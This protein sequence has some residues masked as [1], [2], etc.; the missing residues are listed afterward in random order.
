MHRKGGGNK[1]PIIIPLEGSQETNKTIDPRDE[2]NASEEKSNNEE[3]KD[4]KAVLSEQS[5]KEFTT[6]IQ[7]D[8]RAEVISDN[9]LKL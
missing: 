1:E 9:S 2:I 3:F 6:L 5:K 8:E 7:S 4:P